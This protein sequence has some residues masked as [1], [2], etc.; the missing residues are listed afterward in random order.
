MYSQHFVYQTVQIKYVIMSEPRLIMGSSFFREWW[1]GVVV[2][3]GEGGRR[4]FTYRHDT[5]RAVAIDECTDNHA[6][7]RCSLRRGGLNFASTRQKKDHMMTVRRE[8]AT[9]GSQVLRAATV[10]NVRPLNGVMEL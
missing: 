5:P 4:R 1:R 6:R 8:S 3:R 10:L 2:V 7:R 9:S